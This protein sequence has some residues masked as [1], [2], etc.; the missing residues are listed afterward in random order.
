MRALAPLAFALALLAGPLA[1]QTGV[2][3]GTITADPDAPVEVSAGEMVVDQDSGQVTLT[4]DVRIAQGDLRL[5]AARVRLRYDADGSITAISASGGVTMTTPTEAAEAASADYDLTAST[6]V[7]QGD[8]LITQGLST[9][10]AETMRVDLT[11]GNATLSGR[12]QTIF[13]GRE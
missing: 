5:A 11:T 13:G 7:M 12:V 3:F 1:A 9:I 6:L 4:G 8:V 2:N 10:S